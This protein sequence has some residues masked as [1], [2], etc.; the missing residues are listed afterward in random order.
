MTEADLLPTSRPERYPG[1]SVAN[2]PTGM[3]S[4]VIKALLFIPIR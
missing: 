3:W 2:P 1:H 4:P